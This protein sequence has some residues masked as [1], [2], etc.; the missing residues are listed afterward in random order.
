MKLL[1]GSIIA[2]SWIRPRATASSSRADARPF[3]W[4][5]T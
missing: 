3:C 1:V 5:K 4:R 2:A